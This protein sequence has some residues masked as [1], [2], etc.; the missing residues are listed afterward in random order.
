MPMIDGHLIAHYDDELYT[1]THADLGDWM[2]IKVNHKTQQVEVNVDKR[3]DVEAWHLVCAIML[4][5]DILHRMS[6]L[7][8]E[9][10]DEGEHAEDQ[11]DTAMADG[12]R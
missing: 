8:I 12:C 3:K 2:Q 4:M 7:W 5:S 9:N 10:K 11:D 6:G 1:Y